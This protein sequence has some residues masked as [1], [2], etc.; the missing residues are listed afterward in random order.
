MGKRT[1]STGIRMDQL[2]PGVKVRLT[3]GKGVKKGGFNYLREDAR[4]KVVVVT[5]VQ[6]FKKD[7]PI[8]VVSDN[9]PWAPGPLFVALEELDPTYGVVIPKSWTD[10]TREL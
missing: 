4:G 10:T 7:Y 2:K 1:K 8:E 5:Q 3:R 6:S 9:K